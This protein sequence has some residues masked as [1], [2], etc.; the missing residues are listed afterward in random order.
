MKHQKHFK[1]AI[2]VPCYNE[3]ER[4]PFQEFLR[5]SKR[6][7]ETLL[8]FVDDGSTDNTIADLRGLQYLCPRH[9]SVHQ[10][11]K[12]SGKAEA[13]RQ[14]VLYVYDHFDADAIG[15]LDADLATKP[16]E[17][18]EMARYKQG[19][20]RYGAAIGSRIRRLGADIERDNDRS[21]FSAIARRMIS[22]ILK[23]RLQDSQCGAKVFEKHLVPA[24]FS[25]P[26]IT[27]WLFDVEIFLRLKRKF[28]NSTL[29]NGVLEFPLREWN[30]IG[31]SKLKLKDSIK[32]PLQLLKLH[33]RYNILKA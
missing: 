31:D 30:E 3:H 27:S 12:N 4:F 23:A 24:L 2:V 20:P 21:F 1:Y 9:I 33:Y 22:K 16:Q 8:C 28:G 14:G 7:P 18:L 11:S 5:F 25:K 13:V 29:Q 6:N 19:L 17:W 10:L 32:I 26:F 15:F